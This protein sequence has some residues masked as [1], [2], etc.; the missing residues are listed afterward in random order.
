M[1]ISDWSSDVCSSDLSASPVIAVTAISRPAY[2][3]REYARHEY[4]LREHVA[5]SFREP[6]LVFD[7]ETIP[8]LDGGRRIMGLAQMND[9]EVWAAMKTQRLPQKGTD[10]MQIGRASCRERVCQYG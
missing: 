5:M 3:L 4:S 7:I 10:F 2:S 6:V 1:R 8:D 9:A